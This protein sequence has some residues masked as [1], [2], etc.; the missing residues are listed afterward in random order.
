V[1]EH[2]RLTITWR[3]RTI[4]GQERTIGECTTYIAR[5]EDQIR[6][7]A[8][9]FAGVLE[10]NQAT[11]AQLD[12]RVQD[13]A[14]ANA[15]QKQMIDER[16]A[17]IKKQDELVA[18][19]DA[20]IAQQKTRLQDFDQALTSARARQAEVE[21]QALRDHQELTSKAAALQGEFCTVQA[22]L[23]AALAESASCQSS[24]A[25]TQRLLEESKTLVKHQAD[26][27]DKRTALIK[28]L[29]AMIV[30]RDQA[31]RNQTLMIQE[32]DTAIKN[33]TRMID[34]RDAAIKKQTEMIDARDVWIRN[35]RAEIAAL[36]GDLERQKSWSA[37]LEVTLAERDLSLMQFEARLNE[38]DI[39]L[40]DTR[41]QYSSLMS[42]L[43]RPLY[44]LKRTAKAMVKKVQPSGSSS[45]DA[46]PVNGG[47]SR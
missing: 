30:D 11:I 8:A 34:D 19:R 12:N 39:L 10:R 20:T 35:L 40:S 47:S 26:L 32:R 7:S 29:E 25:Q 22:A 3:D 45:P 2:E 38:R 23:R 21:E 46:T 5:L 42:E 6:A 31:I 16:V 9:E 17:L 24:L 1:V 27:I 15:R 33:Q 37:S 18:L 41:A 4:R 14:A 36:K 13:Y 43:D 28:N 44:C